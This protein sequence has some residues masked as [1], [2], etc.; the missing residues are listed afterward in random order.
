MSA[1]TALVLGAGRVARPCVQYLLAK[2]HKVVLVDWSE[3]N[4]NRVL[5][6][7]EAGI[8]VVADAVKDAAD[9][10]Q[11]Y[12]PDVVICLLPGGL[13]TELAVICVENSVSMVGATYISET[14]HS[15]H[16][17]ATAKGISILCELGLD[18]GIDHMSAV[19][20][21]REIHEAGG[22]VEGFWS[23]C[24][25][26]PDLG[27]NTNP[28]GYKLSWAPQSLIGA[29]I[30]TSKTMKDG[31]VVVLE[32]G[33]V[34]QQATFHEVKGLGWFEVYANADSLP[35][36]EAYGMPEVKNIFR[37]TFR[38][39]GW[40]DMITQMQK[41]NLFDT[42]VKDY[43]GY[44]YAAVIRE[45]IGSSDCVAPL[46]QQVAKFLNLESYSLSIQQL[47]WLGLFENKPLPFA[48]GCLRDIVAALFDEKLQFTAGERDL[49][50]MQHRYDVRYPDE[51]MKT[52]VSTLVVRG[53][54][55]GDTA[56][57]VTTGVPV[58][59]GAHLLLTGAI[60]ERGV[61]L[62]TSTDITV[63]SL[64]ELKDYG[65]VFSEEVIG[66]YG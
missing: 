7:H 9:L 10:I 28:I 5:M 42:D 37:G 18:P 15:L 50:V 65:I 31:E 19:M 1:K 20:T 49:I 8:P 22:K 55:D 24:G 12:K 27:S 35:Y 2:G 57:A 32:D 13:I 16:E 48:S 47:E 14:I 62:P 51:E 61:L 4:I 58:G 64:E 52:H 54:V 29:S 26:L 30:R 53:E 63:P 38:H 17:Q 59:I 36:I 25:A 41:L 40:C 43:S 66:H 34:Y 46:T 11:T 56:I 6:G 21:I 60:S 44:T 33:A 45:I 39:P 23:V 3:E